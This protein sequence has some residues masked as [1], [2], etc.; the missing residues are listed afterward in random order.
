MVNK[1]A[2]VTRTTGYSSSSN[3]KVISKFRFPIK[4]AELTL[5]WAR[6]VNRQG[7]SPSAHS[8]LCELHFNEELI[9]RSGKSNLRWH[10]HP[11]PNIYPE[12]LCATPSV[13]PTI[14]STRKSPQKRIYQPDQ[15]DLFRLKDKITCLNDIDK[16]GILAG[17]KKKCDDDYILFYKL[18]FN[19]VT[20]FPDHTESIKIDSE[21]HV[22]LQFNGTP[23]P[24]P[25]W[26]THG[27]NAKLNKMSMLENF[28][29]H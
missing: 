21:L 28:H 15:L 7:W 3:E 20:K 27:H 8:V 10:L 25:R 23:L 29:L 13:L 9:N 5:K 6:F 4:N 24:L 1:C 12:L 17:F 2:A 18:D 11:V 19:E 14:A 16:D 26:F 22:Q